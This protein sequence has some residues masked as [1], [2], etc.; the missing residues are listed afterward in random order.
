M[1]SAR[2]HR[3]LGFPRVDYGPPCWCGEGYHLRVLADRA[4]DKVGGGCSSFGP[5]GWLAGR[6]VYRAEAEAS[7]SALLRRVVDRWGARTA[8][9]RLSGAVQSAV[10]TW[11]RRSS[12][13]SGSQL[14]DE[15]AVAPVLLAPRGPS[16]IW[17]S[18]QFLT[19][20]RS[21]RRY[22]GYTPAASR[23]DFVLD[24]DRSAPSPA[25]LPAASALSFDP[26]ARR[27]DMRLGCGRPVLFGWGHHFRSAFCP[28]VSLADA[29]LGRLRPQV[30]EDS[31]FT[32][33]PGVGTGAGPPLLVRTPSS[34]RSPAPDAPARSSS[35]AA[36]SADGGLRFS[37]GVKPFCC[38]RH[39]GVRRANQRSAAG[40]DR[41]SA[42]GRGCDHVRRSTRWRRSQ[43][44]AASSSAGGN[45]CGGRSGRSP[46]DPAGSPAC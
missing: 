11:C 42:A 8:S 41:S 16:R 7:N 21:P 36:A 38:R 22:Q 17:N 10:R 5:R 1:A 3:S 14:R 15:V 30:M 24:R 33:D 29:E 23:G 25:G 32:A 37:Q 9:S 35:K 27:R 19:G 2:Q 40:G 18:A 12:S 20:S 13:G 43:Q 46:T 34:G 44:P 4:P 39:A 26:S 28:D 6:E 31:E 45:R